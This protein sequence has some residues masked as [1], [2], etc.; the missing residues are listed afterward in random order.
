MRFPVGKSFVKEGEKAFEKDFKKALASVEYTGKVES[1][2]TQTLHVTQFALV[3][4]QKA[5]KAVFNRLLSTQ[6]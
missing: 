6:A 1:D 4:K 5:A 3:E 2:H